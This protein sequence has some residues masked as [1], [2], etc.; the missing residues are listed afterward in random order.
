MCDKIIFNIAL[1]WKNVVIFAAEETNIHEQR[2]LSYHYDVGRGD[3]YRHIYV[4]RD[5]DDPSGVKDIN[6]VF[7][8]DSRLWTQAYMAY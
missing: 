8:R 2:L 4:Y 1:L 3:V 6:S 7:L 5:R